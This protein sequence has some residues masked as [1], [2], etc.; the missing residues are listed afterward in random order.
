MQNKIILNDGIEIEYDDAL[1]DKIRKASGK[2]SKDL[3]SNQEIAD[4][5]KVA[6]QKALNKGY[7][8]V[9]I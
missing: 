1:L 5:F 3:V 6:F 7:G 4:F 9:E 2:G 8:E